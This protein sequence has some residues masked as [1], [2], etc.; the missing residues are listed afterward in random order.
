MIYLLATNNPNKARE[1]KPMFEA[2]GL[3]LITLADLG[4][5]F[6]A[7]E[8]GNTFTHN[9]TQ[10]ATETA[11]FLKESAHAATGEY[12][13][14]LSPYNIA[15]LADDSGLKI[16]ALGGEP[17]VDSALYLGRDTPF[18]DKCQS[19]LDRLIATPDD[20]RTARF[21]SVMVCV[22]PCGSRLVA[23]G[24]IEGR[25]AHALKGEGGFGYDPIFHYPPYNKTMA[26]LTQDEKNRISHR[27]QATQTMIGLIVNEGTGSK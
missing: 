20:K 9:A 24:T 2:A 10:K 19:L 1:I 18:A 11:A 6:E 16:D 4:L 26:E 14:L 7:E 27:G 15:V 22:M 25:I 12:A 3:N 8:S 21:I 5:Y 13:K 23:E 17:G